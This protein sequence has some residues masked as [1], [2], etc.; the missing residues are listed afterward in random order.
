MVG[1]LS[2]ETLNALRGV[3]AILVLLFHLA[4]DIPALPFFGS[5]YL[6]VDLF[7]MMSGFVIA[8]AYEDK[9]RGGLGFWRFVEI[10]V[11]R[12]YPLYLLGLVIATVPLAALWVRHGETW[13]LHDLA[14]RL[15]WGVTLLPRPA[16]DPAQWWTLDPPAWSLFYELA[17]NFAYAALIAVLSTACWLWLPR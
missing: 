15:A 11:I 6:S 3:A 5:A 1:R 8:Y 13:R 16:A 14:R 10:R 4:P 2:F 7:F 12:L 17:L 9:P